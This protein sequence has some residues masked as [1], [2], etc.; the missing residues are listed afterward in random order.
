MKKIINILLYVFLAFVGIA[1]L[2]VV[3][4]FYLE[5]KYAA[6]SAIP[7]C[8]F[9][10]VIRTIQDNYDLFVESGADN[11]QR[12]IDFS[13]IKEYCGVEII[14]SGQRLIDSK[15]AEIVIKK[16][17]KDE[18]LIRRVNGPSASFYSLRF[19]EVKLV[20]SDKGK[21]KIE[22]SEINKRE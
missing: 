16:N 2:I 21:V 3:K 8:Q 14:F 12:N 6:E 19:D 4:N 13:H 17:N 5:H 7:R 9:Q 11:W 10:E 15:G 20:L 22:I 18:V 1:V